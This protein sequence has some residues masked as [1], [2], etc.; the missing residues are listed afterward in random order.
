MTR[1]V[2]QKSERPGKYVCGDASRNVGSL[3]GKI[4]IL[5]VQETKWEGKSE[6]ELEDGYKN[7]YYDVSN[8]RNGVCIIYVN[9]LNNIW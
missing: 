5:C 1:K 7:I 2:A 6:R 9:E 8:T 4:Y 3:T